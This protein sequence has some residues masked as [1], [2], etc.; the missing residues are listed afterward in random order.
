MPSPQ[1][2]PPGSAVESVHVFARHCWSVPHGTPSSTVMPVPPELKE[3]HPA[4]STEQ[5][6]EPHGAASMIPWQLAL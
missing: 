4:P 5:I 6:T 3:K 1:V 2:L